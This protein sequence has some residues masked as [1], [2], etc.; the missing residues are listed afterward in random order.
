MSGQVAY[1]NP[2]WEDFIQTVMQEACQGLGVDIAASQ[3]GCHLKKALLSEGGG[4]GPYVNSTT[5]RRSIPLTHLKL[6]QTQVDECV[7]SLSSE[8]LH[9]TTLLCSLPDGGVFAKLL[10]SLPSVCDG[11]A[12]H[13]EH[14]GME[15]DAPINSSDLR[16]MAATR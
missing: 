15:V 10:T 8:A 2:D 16:C 5:L 4:E 13:V 1:G 6:S 7:K 11:G 3:P 14:L 12:L 9:S